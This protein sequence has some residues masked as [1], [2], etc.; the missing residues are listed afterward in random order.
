[1]NP[2][3]TQEM[4]IMIKT[5]IVAA[6]LAISSP[7]ASA[8]QLPFGDS[9]ST[10]VQLI[11]APAHIAADVDRAAEHFTRAQGMAPGVL[12]RASSGLA[13][14]GIKW[15]L[16]TDPVYDAKSQELGKTLGQALASLAQAITK[17]MIQTAR[18]SLPAR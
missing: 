5:A 16:Y 10:E 14:H 3:T 15:F 12:A 8:S 6:T 17:D 11:P 7:F 18:Q 2:S 9:R 4:A 1:M 13:Q